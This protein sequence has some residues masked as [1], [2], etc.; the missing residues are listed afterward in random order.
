MSG[1]LIPF[2]MPVH[3]GAFPTF[4]TKPIDGGGAQLCPC[5]LATPTPQ[6]FTV[7]SQPATLYRPKSSPPKGGCAPHSSPYP[8]DLSWRITA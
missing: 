5:D 2:L 3:P 8:P 7:A 4:T 6:T 1:V